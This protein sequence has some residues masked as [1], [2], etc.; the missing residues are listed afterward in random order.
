MDHRP[1]LLTVERKNLL[2]MMAQRNQVRGRT[3]EWCAPQYRPS[4]RI[5]HVQFSVQGEETMISHRRAAIIVGVLYIIGTVAGVLS[6][7]TAGT[8]LN[9]SAYLTK[10]SENKDQFVLGALSVLTMGLALAMVS[11]VI[12]PILKQENEVLAVGYVLFRGGLETVTYIA[13]V[14]VW[15]MLLALSQQFV[16]AGAPEASYFQ[17]W[18]A[19]LNTVSDWVAELISIVFPLSALMLYYVLYRSKLIPRWLSGWGLLALIP[20]FAATFLAMFDVITLAGGTEDLLRMPLALQEMVMA[21]W[22]IAKGFNLHAVAPLPSAS[23][24]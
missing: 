5:S 2:S 15:F 9:D 23:V 19:A 22:L 21:V 12:F 4:R 16:K 14:I 18:G 11:V 1:R 10:I 24:K 13:S 8:I 7:A 6:V 20:Y 3:V 17:T